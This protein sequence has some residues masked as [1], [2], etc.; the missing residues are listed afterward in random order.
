MNEYFYSY[1]EME[2]DIEQIVK[3]IETNDLK[4]IDIYGVP[5]GGLILAVRLS[6]ILNTRLLLNPRYISGKTLVV[7]DISDSGQTLQKIKL[8]GAKV[9][10]IFSRTNTKVIPNYFVR[11]VQHEVDWIHFWWEDGA[12]EKD[13]ISKTRKPVDDSSG[14]DE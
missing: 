8:R 6:Y 14:L 2:E 10:T 3:W 4:F 13:T 12:T 1:Y 9:V 7:D 11:E 5:R